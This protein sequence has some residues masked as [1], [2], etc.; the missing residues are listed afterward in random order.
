VDWILDG[1]VSYFSRTQGQSSRLN[2][3]T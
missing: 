2:R 3:R 1:G